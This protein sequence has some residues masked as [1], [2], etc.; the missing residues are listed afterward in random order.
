MSSDH[1]HEPLFIPSSPAATASQQEGDPTNDMEALRLAQALSR[2]LTRRAAENETPPRRVRHELLNAIKCVGVRL[3]DSQLQF[4]QTSGSQQSQ[5]PLHSSLRPPTRQPSESLRSRGTRSASPDRTQSD[6]SSSPPQDRQPAAAPPPPPR[7]PPKAP[8]SSR[9][10]VAK[11]RLAGILDAYD[12][13][14]APEGAEHSLVPVRD[15]VALLRGEGGEK[16]PG[17]KSGHAALEDQALLRAIRGFTHR[18]NDNTTA[19]YDEHLSGFPPDWKRLPN[20]KHAL[21][22]VIDGLVEKSTQLSNNAPDAGVELSKRLSWH[23]KDVVRGFSW[24]NS[25]WHKIETLCV[26]INYTALAKGHEGL[27]RRK[28]LK[29]EFFESW[30]GKDKKH[31]ARLPPDASDEAE[32]ESKELRARFEKAFGEASRARSRLYD[33]YMNLGPAIILDPFWTVEDC[34]HHTSKSMGQLIQAM[35]EHVEHDLVDTDDEGGNATGEE[36]AKHMF[37]PRTRLTAQ[38]LINLAGYLGS[39]KFATYVHNFIV[40]YPSHPAQQTVMTGIEYTGGDITG[41]AEEEE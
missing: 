35:S 31:L 20:H 24:V 36:K 25:V 16:M 15:L 11:T 17:Q 28:G 30:L 10:T 9:E 7:R 27:T 23:R 3:P 39:R 40:R 22:E 33:L 19:E 26:H 37:A 2:Y 4:S 5:A 41:D 1:E 21:D 18:R 38:T 32:E 14:L 12:A 6:R 13:L 34:Y 29:N 8:K